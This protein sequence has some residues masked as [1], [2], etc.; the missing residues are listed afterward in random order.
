MKTASFIIHL[1]RAE[2]RK[3]QVAQLQSCLPQPVETLPAVDGV[4]M[5]S[6]DRSTAYRRGLHRPRY[7]FV[8]RDAEIGTFLSHRRAWSEIISRGLDFALIVED[9]IALNP[10]EFARAH[11]LACA[12]VT[13]H[14][15]VR[16]PWFA[17]EVPRTEIVRDADCSLFSP[18][19]IGLGML[20]QLVS[21]NAAQKLLS[22]TEAFDRPVDTLLQMHWVTGLRPLVVWPSGV[23]EV[24]QT[25]GGSTIAQR[26]SPAQAIWREI[27]RP[28]YRGQIA[29]HSRFRQD[30]QAILHD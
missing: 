15:Y 2:G 18:R 16:F 8:L 14:G 24:S 6:A 23:S 17:K 9:D 12:H 20:A 5:S 11:A 28:I 21:R 25:L 29:I 30:A 19:R 26:K 10:A 7:P 3:T 1:E 4:A 13:E 27:M 22:V